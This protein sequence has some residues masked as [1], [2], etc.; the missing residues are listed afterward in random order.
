M[1]ISHDLARNLDA[2][3]FAEAAGIIPDVW[4]SDLLRVRPRRALLCC[5]R[6]S[7]KTTV[8]ALLG[9]HTSL[10]QSNAL[11][12]VVSPS[13]RQSAELLRT[14]KNLHAHLDD[15]TPLRSESVLKL[16]W[17]NGSR[18]LALPGTEK[19]VRGFAGASLV[20]VDEAARVEDELLQAVRPM[21]ATNA[22][23][24]LIA[25]STPNGRRG[26]F[27]E[28]W[29]GGD[30]VWH[31]VEIPASQ[32]P[33]ISAE[34]LA[35][36]RKALGETRFQEEYNLAFLDSGVAAFPTDLIDAMFTADVKPLWS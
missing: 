9:L 23:G 21:L 16:E 18:L 26:W 2:S 32:C 17:E 6:Q 35:E 13:Q 8:T 7:G 30:P 28:A 20:I 22:K 36:E 31:R 19:T 5:S 12:V 3:L 29:T 27:F 33:R 14:V 11:T 25:L 15:A 24:S 34:F 4:Q 1:L 10:Y